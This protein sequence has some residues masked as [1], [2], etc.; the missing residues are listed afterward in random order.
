M[1]CYA[2]LIYIIP[3]YTIPTILRLQGSGGRLKS[4]RGLGGL[5]TTSNKNNNNNTKNSNDN[6]SNK[7]NTWP[8]S[9]RPSS[10]RA[11]ETGKK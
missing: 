1:L 6:N 3:Y 7:Y 9:G 8:D 2:M 4:A 11:A 5:T 10:M